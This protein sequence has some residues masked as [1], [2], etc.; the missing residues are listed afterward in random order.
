MAVPP[1]TVEALRAPGAGGLLGHRDSHRALDRYRA[2]SFFMTT[3]G[4]GSTDLRMTVS[5][6]L[7]P[8]FPYEPAHSCTRSR[9][10][11]RHVRAP[12]HVQRP[13]LRHADARPPLRPP[14][15]PRP[16][17]G[18]GPALPD[19]HEQACLPDARRLLRRAL[20]GARPADVEAGRSASGGDRTALFG[21]PGALLRLSSARLADSSPSPRP[22]LPGRRQPRPPGG[23][24]VRGCG[25]RLARRPRPRPRGMHSSSCG[26]A[27]STTL[28]LVEAAQA[29]AADASRPTPCGG[30][31]RACCSLS[32]RSSG[33]GAV[34]DRHAAR[35]GRCGHGLDRGRRIR[36][37]SKRPSWRD[38]GGAAASRV[39]D[40]AFAL[41]R[42]GTIA[43]VGRTPLTVERR[44]RRSAA[45][46]RRPNAARNANGAGPPPRPRVSRAS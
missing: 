3:M 22:Q 44:L 30:S 17:P 9:P 23:G 1:G 4:A 6:Y 39:L 10:K 11:P 31:P 8:D 28:E 2:P 37:A 34:D 32:A 27:S 36:D 24:A 45:G 40:I 7:L 26:P 35:V 21:G 41:G 20:G 19:E 29:V 42:G 14:P 18:A 43:E 15:S 46:S 16:L 25:R 5:Q 12:G 38:G 13:H 33:R